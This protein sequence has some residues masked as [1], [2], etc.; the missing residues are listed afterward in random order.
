[1]RDIFSRDISGKLRRTVPP[2]VLE[3]TSVRKKDRYLRWLSK[4]HAFRYELSKLG[5][6]KAIT[7]SNMVVSDDSRLAYIKNSKVGCTSISSGI[8]RYN[9][10]E[11]PIGDIHSLNG[12]LRQGALYIFDNLSAIEKGATAFSFVRDPVARARSAFFNFFVDATNPSAQRHRHAIEAR[13]FSSTSDLS[14]RFDVF[15][16]YVQ[17][18][19]SLSRSRTD[20][21]WRPQV[22]NTGI[23]MVPIAHIGKMEDGIEKGLRIVAEISGCRPIV[24]APQNLNQSSRTDFSPTTSQARKIRLIYSEDYETF[25]Y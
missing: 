7:F 16:D 17:E 25:G 23:N 5:D 3:R 10:G 20:R 22:L 14:Y 21:H 6:A 4:R 18:S 11:Y 9:T 19:M 13:G 15:L 12:G 24:L 1:M 8:Y 2:V